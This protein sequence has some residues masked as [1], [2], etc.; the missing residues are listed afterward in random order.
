MEFRQFFERVL[1]EHLLYTIDYSID[2]ICLSYYKVDE[3]NGAS[4]IWN[5]TVML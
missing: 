5:I 3:K 2:D 1:A 4:E